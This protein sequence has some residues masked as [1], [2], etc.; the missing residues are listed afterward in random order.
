MLNNTKRTRIYDQ[1]GSNQSKARE[2]E[3]AGKQTKKLLRLIILIFVVIIFLTGVVQIP[4]IVSK[5]SKPFSQIPAE[6]A[7]KTNPN[8][9]FR[10]NILLATVEGNKLVELGALSFAKGDRKLVLVKFSPGA[11]ISGI[12]ADYSFN[13]LFVTKEQKFDIDRLEAGLIAA[14]GYPLDGYVVLTNGQSL[15]NQTRLEKL[16]DNFY[17]LGFFFNLKASKD[18]LD[19]NLKTN[20]TVNNANDLIWQ[21][22]SLTPDRI[23][24]IDLQSSQDSNGYLDIQS[25]NNKLGLLLADASISKEGAAVE[26]VNSSSVDGVGNILKTLIANLGGN[27]LNVTKAEESGKTEILSKDT[28][29]PLAKKLS[30][31]TGAKIKK[32]K[33]SET[34]GDI[35][36]II[37]SD[38][39]KFF[40]F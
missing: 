29:S 26:I 37:G 12:K 15:V 25:A 23:N 24:F 6:F 38:Y 31:M 33:N 9:N 5:I 11:R 7:N 13:D 2:Q 20:L 21:A 17:S 1:Q 27:V 32:A 39:A 30:E 19:K 35:K 8:L 22:K 18:Y 16:I 36:L 4:G 34:N 10:T 40:N 14:V 28:N 3:K